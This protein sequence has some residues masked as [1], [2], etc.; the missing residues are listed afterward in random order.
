M[1]SMGALSLF[2]WV[3]V[4]V[5]AEAQNRSIRG[6]G[7][8]GGGFQIG[9]GGGNGQQN[10]QA[11]Q[12]AIQQINQQLQQGQTLFQEASERAT[13]VRGE[14]QKVDTE[15]KQNLREL[16]QAKKL[17]EE[18]AKNSPELKAARN[19][20]EALRSELAEVRKKVIEK[21]TAESEEYQDAIKA[22]EAAVAEQKANSGPNVS[23]EARRELVKKVSEADRRKK[24]IE[25]A[26]L[27]ENTDAKTLNQQLKDALAEVAAIV[28]SNN[29]AIESD[30]TI[31]SAKVA[32]QRSRDD[33][34][35]AK[36]ELAQAEGEVNRIRTA[37][38]Q[39]ANQR[40][41]LEAQIQL[42][43]RQQQNGGGNQ[44]NGGRYSRPR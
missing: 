18:A 36:A 25:D 44:Q 22:H 23:Q 12:Q 37:M 33:L 38:Q 3:A 30:P 27:T 43:Q 11:M 8:R 41:A 31:N 1:K 20:V 42:Q 19:K 26:A 2:L 28:K 4:C 16:A 32:F 13:E 10:T 29:E 6:V 21:L 17:A 40:T 39:L 14:Y 7:G 35:K 24:T 9:A 5:P 15:H 34:K